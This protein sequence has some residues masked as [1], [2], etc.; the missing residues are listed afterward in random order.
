[1]SS[2]CGDQGCPIAVLSGW[3]N[4]V[5]RGST[6]PPMNRHAFRAMVSRLPSHPF[7]MVG[8]ILWT[9][10]VPVFPLALERISP[11]MLRDM[12]RPGT[13]RM[14]KGFDCASASLPNLPGRDGCHRARVEAYIGPSYFSKLQ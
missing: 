5:R 8:S 12:L 13:L 2:G 14:T 1:M 10:V 11:R 7:L 4:A 6:L 3:T 9:N